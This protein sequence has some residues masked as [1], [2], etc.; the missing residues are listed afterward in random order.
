L[1]EDLD[2]GQSPS[3]SPSRLAVMG[4]VDLLELPAKPIEKAV[5]QR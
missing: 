3:P 4:E 5:S 1:E 2:R